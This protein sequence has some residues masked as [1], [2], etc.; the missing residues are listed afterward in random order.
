MQ[1]LRSSHNRCMA[2]KSIPEP[3]QGPSDPSTV[4]P[5]LK[6]LTPFVLAV[7]AVLAFQCLGMILGGALRA[8]HSLCNFNFDIHLRRS[9][10]K[11]QIVPAT[12][13]FLCSFSV[14]GSGSP[15]QEPWISSSSWFLPP[16]YSI[17]L[18]INEYLRPC[19]LSSIH[20]KT[21]CAP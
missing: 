5:Y 15:S 19:G 1:A 21:L 12:G 9:S 10:P 11:F 13:A 7:L 20:D 6:I 8:Q 16:P 4:P 17:F 3:D 18:T 2:L 14:A